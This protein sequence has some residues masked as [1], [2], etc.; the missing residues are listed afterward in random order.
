[1][2][3]RVRGWGLGT[4][5]Q[6]GIE[7]VQCCKDSIKSCT[8]QKTVK[9]ANQILPPDVPSLKILIQIDLHGPQEE[10]IKILIGTVKPFLTKAE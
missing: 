5:L 10:A 6:E 7:L 8:D 3:G 9:W 4:R 1:M 2:K